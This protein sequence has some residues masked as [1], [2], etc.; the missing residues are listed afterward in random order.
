MNFIR[1]LGCHR[2]SV[3][4]NC[5]RV[6]HRPLSSCVASTTSRPGLII[7]PA[8]KPKLWSPVAATVRCVSIFHGGSRNSIQSN[9]AALTVKKRPPR[10][11]RPVAQA[12]EGKFNVVAYATAHEYDLDGLHLALIRT[13]Q[14][15][16][17]KFYA[18][19]DQEVLHIRIKHN[20][21]GGEPFTGEPQEVFFFREGSTVLWNCDDEQTRLIWQ[22]LSAYEVNAYEAPVVE[23]EKEIMDYAYTDSQNGG[24]KQEVFWLRA[25]ESN[26][27]FKYTYSNAMTSSVKLAMWEAK[28]NEYIDGLAEVTSDLKNGKSLRMTRAAVLQKTG[29]LFAL[30]HL[31]NL[32]SEL[33]GTPDFY[34]EHESLEKLFSKTCYYFS[35]PKRKRVSCGG[36][37]YNC[38]K[39]GFFF[40][41][42]RL[43]FLLFSNFFDFILSTSCL[44][45]H[46]FVFMSRFR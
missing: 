10:K 3:A 35:V 20:T 17:R 24:L 22:Y 13:D 30:K 23:D 2:L 9:V 36:D 40:F 7:G 38:L 15:E 14:F 29:E 33:L 39:L 34:W 42:S 4:S 37:F 11:K 32:N 25:N 16:T 27:L 8:L 43:L 19:S 18:D 12:K 28:L 41:I 26:D 46:A 21:D 31:V 45:L 5:P 44:R 1:R 6:N